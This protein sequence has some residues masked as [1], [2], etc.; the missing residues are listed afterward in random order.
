MLCAYNFL[1][2]L[3]DI[4]AS[5]CHVSRRLAFSCLKKKPMTIPCGSHALALGGIC[6]ALPFVIS[7]R[8][9]GAQKE[10]VFRTF[11]VETCSVLY[12]K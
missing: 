12:V 4:L 5:R 6:P 3:I 2:V 10:K 9:I 11:P 7:E 8:M 1:C